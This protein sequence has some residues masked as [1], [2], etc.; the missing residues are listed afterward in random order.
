[1]TRRVSYEWVVEEL[2]EDGDIVEPV[3]FDSFAE[4]AAYGATLAR[5]DIGLV[6][7]EGDELEGLTDRLWSYARRVDGK[8][9]LAETFN[10]GGDEFPTETRVPARFLREVGRAA[11]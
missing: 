3:H 1:M 2:D 9:T 6:R 5:A 7:N 8:W 10:A 11:S 4:A